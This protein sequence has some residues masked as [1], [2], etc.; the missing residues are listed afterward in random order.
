MLVIVTYPKKVC[1]DERASDQTFW[2]T[3]VRLLKFLMAAKA[4]YIIT[5]TRVRF[6][7]IA[8]IKN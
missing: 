6:V 2:T 3:I 4:K 8:P 7:M 1:L 5:K